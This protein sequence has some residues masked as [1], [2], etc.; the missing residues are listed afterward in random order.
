MSRKNGEEKVALEDAII[1]KGNQQCRYFLAFTL[2]SLARVKLYNSFPFHNIYIQA[3]LRWDL[4]K[5]LT[6]KHKK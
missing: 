3:M 1:T 5:L 6:R 4:G 2:I